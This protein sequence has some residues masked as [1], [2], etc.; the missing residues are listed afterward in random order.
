MAFF[1]TKK[2]LKGAGIKFIDLNLKDPSSKFDFHQRDKSK[3]IRLSR[4]IATT[5]NKQNETPEDSTENNNKYIKRGS[6]TVNNSRAISY[7]GS[8]NNSNIQPQINPNQQ[9]LVTSCDLKTIQLDNV[10]P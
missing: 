8:T 10:L 4:G 9:I 3:D 5:L 2:K 1:E 7:D 6:K